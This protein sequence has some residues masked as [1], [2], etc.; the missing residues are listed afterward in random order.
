M[1]RAGEPDA[2]QLGMEHFPRQSGHDFAGIGPADPDRQHP[3]AA[4]VGRVGVSADDQPAWERVVFQHDLMDDPGA[5]LPEADP[6]LLRSRRQEVVDL[7]I[8][9]D[10]AQQ[11]L[12]GAA[13]GPDQVVAMDRAG[14]RHP[15]LAGLHELQ[16]GHLGGRILHG[17]PVRTQR[18]HRFAPLPDLGLPVVHVRNQDLF[19]Q[20]EAA[21]ELLP[22]PGH[23]VG[24]LPVELL[25][26]FD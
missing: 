13:L 21:P 5:G 10:G 11:V 17:H 19:G 3:E 24:H 25:D 4:A 12:L 6:V 16:H 7:P 20:G 8:L 14:H 2:D 18:Q 23:G 9:V 22:G 1:Q 15:L 26:E